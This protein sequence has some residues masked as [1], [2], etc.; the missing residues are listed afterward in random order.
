MGVLFCTAAFALRVQLQMTCFWR[1][2]IPWREVVLEAGCIVPLSF[3]S[4]GYGCTSSGLRG[5]DWAAFALF[6]VGTWLNLWPEWQRYQWKREPDRLGKL[7]TGSLFA[8]AR[9][10]N[11]TGEI[12]SF[13]GLALLTGSPW[14]LWVPA[15]MGAGMSTASVREIEFYLAQRYHKEWPAYCSKTPWIL[16]PWVY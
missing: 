5:A 8:Y 1:R 11:Y 6:L 4:F 12:L 3:A 14:T 9:H 10:I 7:F 13:V 15:A 16:I 2:S